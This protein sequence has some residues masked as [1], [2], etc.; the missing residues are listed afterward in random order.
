MSSA[1][2][3]L[4]VAMV[5]PLRE[6][7]EDDANLDGISVED[8]VKLRLELHKAAQELEDEIRRKQRE[9]WEQS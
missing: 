2:L 1:I 7:L 4:L 8:A 6:L 3:E 9:H 5:A